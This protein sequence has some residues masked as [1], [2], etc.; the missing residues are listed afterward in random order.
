M[1]RSHGHME[2]AQLTDYMPTLEFRDTA[3]YTEYMRPFTTMMV[4]ALPTAP[5]RIRMYSVSRDRDR[6]FSDRDRLTL[7]LLRPHIDAVHREAA[8]RR[9]EPVRLTPRELDVLRAVANG[10]GT[11]DIAGQFVV[12]P[13]T[14]RKHLENIFRKLDVSSRTAAVARVFPEPVAPPP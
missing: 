6:P 5:G 8:R 1:E 2:V 12:A 11:E 13:S 14:I 4:V 9:R 3:L 10:W 7:Q